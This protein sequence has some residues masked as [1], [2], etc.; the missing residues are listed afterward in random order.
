VW[1]HLVGQDI[2]VV[3][4]VVVEGNSRE[5]GGNSFVLS[6]SLVSTGVLLCDCV[7]M[8]WEGLSAV[9]ITAISTAADDVGKISSW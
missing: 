8:C 1:H 7:I 5:Q 3:V 6:L 9:V 2:G 4:G